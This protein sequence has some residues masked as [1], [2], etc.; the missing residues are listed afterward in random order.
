MYSFKCRTCKNSRNSYRYLILI[1][2]ALPVK[3]LHKIY[4]LRKL[5]LNKTKEITN[6]SAISKFFEN[7]IV[8]EKAAIKEKL[9]RLTGNNINES[10]D[11]FDETIEKLIHTEKIKEVDI[12]QGDCSYNFCV[13][14]III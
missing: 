13:N 7:T 10:N 4:K 1:H 12:I 11:N 9:L 14:K 3:K 6:H 8:Y 5:L 2:S